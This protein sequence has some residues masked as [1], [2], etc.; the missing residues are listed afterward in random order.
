MFV[1]AY[2]EKAEQM[3]VYCN[4]MRLKLYL[5]CLSFLSIFNYETKHWKILSFSTLRMFTKT[6]IPNGQLKTTAGQY[7]LGDAKQCILKL[8]LVTT[9]FD[10][11]IVIALSILFL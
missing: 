1:F 9:N 10:Q 11:N 7:K 2:F 4:K 3:T 6:S 8:L 5:G